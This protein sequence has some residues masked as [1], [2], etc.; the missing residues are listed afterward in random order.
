MKVLI[1]C[2]T[3]KHGCGLLGGCDI[4]WCSNHEKYESLIPMA[5]PIKRRSIQT[6]KYIM[7]DEFLDEREMIL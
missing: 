4:G 5:D 6:G 7:T 1:T 3:C 2:R